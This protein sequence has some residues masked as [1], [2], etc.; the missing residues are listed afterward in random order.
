MKEE[1]LVGVLTGRAV[2]AVGIRL[3]HAASRFIQPPRDVAHHLAAGLV[4]VAEQD[5]GLEFLQPV[6]TVIDP[7]KVSAAGR[8]GYRIA[9]AGLV[10]REGVYLPFRDDLRL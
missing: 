4:V 1:N 9:R 3:D 6:P 5:D 2:R 8:D 7:F 10:E